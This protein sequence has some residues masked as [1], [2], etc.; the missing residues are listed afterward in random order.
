ML[1]L[2]LMYICYKGFVPYCKL[3]K[4]LLKVAVKLLVSNHV[5]GS[6]IF[7]PQLKQGGCVA[8]WFRNSSSVG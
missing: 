6:C 8:L 2:L 7:A 3:C 4:E 5:A 1:L